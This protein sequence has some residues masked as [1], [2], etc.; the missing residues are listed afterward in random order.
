VGLVLGKNRPCLRAVS[1]LR[2]IGKL[3]GGVG[4]SSRAILFLPERDSDHKTVIGTNA[5]QIAISQFTTNHPD[6]VYERA[7]LA[8]FIPDEQTIP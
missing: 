1:G 2:C 3:L 8:A 6:P 5:H 7:V 4:D